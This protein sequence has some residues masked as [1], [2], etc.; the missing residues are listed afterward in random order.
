MEPLQGWYCRRWRRDKGQGI[1][2]KRQGIRERQH[3]FTDTFYSAYYPL[4]LLLYSVFFAYTP[5]G[6]ITNWNRMGTGTVNH[7]EI[8]IQLTETVAGICPSWRRNSG[9]G[10]PGVGSFPVTPYPDFRA[11]VLSTQ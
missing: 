8:K 11:E 3:H 7:I 4:F 5:A 9:K 6:K 1:R 2:D 10:Q